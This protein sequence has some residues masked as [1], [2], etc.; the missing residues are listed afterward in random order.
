MK[1]KVSKRIVGFLLLSLFFY[2][3]TFGQNG[4]EKATNKVNEIS[5]KVNNAI[6]NTI[7]NL[8][9][10]KK[11]ENQTTSSQSSNSIFKKS[12]Y[13]KKNDY[14]EIKSDYTR[15]NIGEN[16]AL[17]IKGIYP[18]NFKPSWKNINGYS[19][20]EFDFENYIASRLSPT[21]INDFSLYELK[22][23]AMVYFNGCVG[24]VVINSQSV[25][26]SDEPKT[27]RITN[28]KNAYNMENNCCNGKENIYRAGLEGEITLSANENG[29]VKIKLV[30][31]QYRL[32]DQFSP[33]GV[34]YRW[35]KNDL[36]VLNE[37]SVEKAIA[38][39]NIQRQNFIKDSLRAI[40]MELKAKEDQKLFEIKIKN[41]YAKIYQVQK[42]Y[43]NSQNCLKL[44]SGTRT[45][46][47]TRYEETFVA[48]PSSSEPG[49]FTEM[50]SKRIPVTDYRTVSFEGLKNNCKNSITILG[51][52]K[53][54]SDLGT[55][56]YEDA[57]IKLEPDAM[58]DY[59]L[60]IEDN[61]NPKTAEIGSTHYYKNKIIVK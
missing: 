50:E 39:S 6:S 35:T 9:N 52:R 33:A 38:I 59:K 24:E 41:S 2:E 20:I 23:K 46:T 7:P 27:F 30:F 60:D 48:V 44:Y 22:S 51:I 45:E 1:K 10:K 17:D 25:I 49:R 42:G 54:K 28:F 5:N 36:L 58:T 37:M 34:S 29:D 40:A 13:Y 32:A 11:K 16:L 12:V 55:V 56:Y 31:E 21:E 3:C 15:F 26:L 57:S 47:Y 43:N 4:I 18:N 19:H 14:S 53:L 8:F 61:Y